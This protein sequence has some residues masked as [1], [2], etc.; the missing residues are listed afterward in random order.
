MT[1]ILKD[2]FKM[3]NFEASDAAAMVAG[4]NTPTIERDTTIELPW[5]LESVSWWIS[6]ILDAAKREPISERHFIIEVDGKLAGSI[7]IINIDGHRGEIG[8]WL[9]DEYA[10]RGIM[11][12]AVGEMV[13]Y[14][15]EDLGLVRIFAPVLTHNKASCRVLEK[16]GFEL[17]GTLN[18]Y[19]KKNG[20]YID[21]LCYAK[22]K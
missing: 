10:G 3:R 20:K 4:L 14:C 5:K 9:S 2:K 19:Y 8:Y 6:F 18:K 21:A 7:G 22:V 15:I 17:E 1:V 13:N 16:N 11:T 12:E